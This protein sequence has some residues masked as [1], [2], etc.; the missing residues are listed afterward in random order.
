MNDDE[1]LGGP[2]E[3]LLHPLIGLNGQRVDVMVADCDGTRLIGARDARICPTASTSVRVCS[4]RW[5]RSP[6][7][8]RT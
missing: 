2:L 4:A 5:S 3:A 6:E 1:G 8:V 7:S